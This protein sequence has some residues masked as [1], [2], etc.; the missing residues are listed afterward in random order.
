MAKMQRWKA[1]AE[2]RASRNSAEENSA[3]GATFRSAG[4]LSQGRSSQTAIRN[5]GG[6]Q[7]KTTKVIARANQAVKD[8]NPFAAAKPGTTTVTVPKPMARVRARAEGEMTNETEDSAVQ[9]RDIK[10]S[11][12]DDPAAQKE[13]RKKRANRQATEDPTKQA[14]LDLKELFETKI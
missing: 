13:G 4:R 12:M 5:V 1:S 9:L 6:H 3:D 8:G 2:R 7:I 14:L 11:I 10:I